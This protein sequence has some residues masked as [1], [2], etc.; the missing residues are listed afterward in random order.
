MIPLTFFLKK[1]SI[2]RKYFFKIFEFLLHIIFHF[3]IVFFIRI[4]DTVKINHTCSI[5]LFTHV[6]KNSQVHKRM[7]W[8]SQLLN[9]SLS[10]VLELKPILKV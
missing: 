10:F 7:R 9:L 5:L 4:K 1:R 3:H 2:L 8:F 6:Q